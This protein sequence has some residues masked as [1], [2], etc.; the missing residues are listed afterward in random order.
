M[1]SFVATTALLADARKAYHALQT[2]TMARVVVDQ[3]NERVEFVAANKQGLYA[4][5][6]QLEAQLGVGCGGTPVPLAQFHPAGF[7]F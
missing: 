1:P 6:Q 4:Y 7:T 2:G 3:N 5:I